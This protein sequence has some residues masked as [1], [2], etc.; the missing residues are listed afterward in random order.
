MIYLMDTF[1]QMSEDLRIS[2]N[3]TVEDIQSVS[4]LYDGY[5]PEGVTSPYA[6]YIYGDAQLEEH[7]LYFNQVKVP[8]FWEIRSNN[9]AGEIFEYQFLRGRIFYQEPSNLRHVR[10]VDIYD[11]NQNIVYTD[12]YDK[13]GHRYSRTY[14]DGDKKRIYRSYFDLED[15]EVIV[16]NYVTSDII[17]TVD[18]QVK[19]FKN[20]IEFT[21]Y[22][23]DQRFD[24][25]EKVVINSLSTPFLVARQR[26]SNYTLFWQEPITNGIPGNMQIIFNEGGNVKVQTSAAFHALS[27][28]GV[29]E[30]IEK[31]GFMYP[32]KRE[33]Q[34]RKQALILTNS[35]QVR[36]LAQLTADFK[37]IHFHIGAITEMSSKLMS[38]ASD[39]VTLYPNIK[40]E[41]VEELLS[42]CDLYFDIN[43]GDMIL[44]A[45]RRSFLEN[46]LIF[47]FQDT[48]HSAQYIAV[49]HIFENYDQFKEQLTSVLNDQA[50]WNQ[51]LDVQKEFA[52]TETKE[53]FQEKINKI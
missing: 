45:L 33:T 22:F 51:A 40:T 18:N 43:H 4:I 34:Y 21:N 12:H 9:S 46:Q 26:G 30:K 27:N 25:D 39:N 24:K 37:D 38:M 15:Q 2:L 50:V 23:L 13:F 17:L 42:T 5:L 28:L 14:F 36:D 8:A 47:A 11:R 6:Y 10:A 29:A 16:E 35:D 31:I 19:I 20:R 3:Q 52:A 41:K 32:F 1:T 53:S 7:P 44:D 48:L 49:E